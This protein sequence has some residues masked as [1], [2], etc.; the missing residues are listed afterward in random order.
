MTRPLTIGTRG[1]LLALW[2]SRHIAQCLRDTGVPQVELQII[3]TTGDRITDRHPSQISEKGIFVKEIE[4]ALLDKS[5]D[6]A[7]HSTKD[8][9]G[10]LPAGLTL[11]AHPER[12]DPRDALITRQG[13]SLDDLPQ[14]AVLGTVSLRR[15]A[16]FLARRP[17]LKFTDMRGNVDTRLRKMEEGEVDG[18]VLAYAGLRRLELAD[19]RCWPVPVEICLPAPGQ[20]VLG[21]ECREDDPEVLEALAKLE[22]AVP[23]R[24]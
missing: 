23:A 2:Q 5:V 4:E 1:S 17:D 24:K 7:V 11:G 6:L 3:K 14:G 20:G 13:L 10:E 21:I 19:H 12:V 22:D 18:I 16:Q 8:L 15:R 9:P